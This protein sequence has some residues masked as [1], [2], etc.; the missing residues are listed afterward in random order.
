MSSTRLDKFYD[1]NDSFVNI[2]IPKSILAALRWVKRWILLMASAVH[3]L[4]SWKKRRR[5]VKA[6]NIVG[7]NR[8]LKEDSF[9]SISIF[10]LLISRLGNYCCPKYCFCK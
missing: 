2:F 4:L 3:Q 10:S 6:N 1:I 9:N 5:F 8:R 7:I